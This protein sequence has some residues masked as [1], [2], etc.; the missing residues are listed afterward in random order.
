M[1]NVMQTS[2]RYYYS[3][4]NE[5]QK[6]I[7]ETIYKKVNAYSS[8]IQLSLVHPNEFG[9]I[10]EAI[11]LDNPEIFY[12][13]AYRYTKDL[14]KK[15]L[16]I[17]PDYTLP[18]NVISHHKRNIASS[19][20]FFETA[21][22]MSEYEKIMYVHNYVLD[23]ITYD[24][25]E[26]AHTVLGIVKD[27]KGVCEGIA[28][29]VKLA[30]DYLSLKSIVVIG[31]AVNPAFELDVS[32]NHAWNMVAING[33]W[34]H[35]DVTFDLTLKH[36]NNRYDYFLVGDSELK[37]SHS[38]GNRQPASTSVESDY[39]FINGLAVE[40]ATELGRII[41]ENLSKGHRTFQVKL[42]NIPDGFD[43]TEKVMQETETQCQRV[44]N[45]YSIEVRYNNI[46]W[47][48]EIDINP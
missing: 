27:R 4:L 17:E 35:L 39:Y 47:I 5:P 18:Q 11:L 1:V 26:D 24:Y 21:R 33:N 48:Y 2:Y 7:Y 23:N 16:V 30:L 38:M 12:F 31:H 32:E 13:N 45:S 25:P 15:R 10:H 8:C 36:K 43:P 37:R 29:Y 22:Q 40:N 34:Y 44:F 42:R 6:K 3:L 28:K 19:V 46:L 41:Y 9:L 20:S 14:N